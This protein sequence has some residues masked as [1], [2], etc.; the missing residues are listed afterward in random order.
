MKIA[1]ALSGGGFRAT[2]FHLGVLARLAHEKRLEEVKFL[3]TVSG[4]SLCIGLVFALNNNQW[5]ASENY[6]QEILPETRRLIT[7]FDL[8]RSMIIRALTSFW[9]IFETRADDLSALMQKHWGMTA[10]LRDLPKAPRFSAVGGYA[11]GQF[12]PDRPTSEEDT[13][14]L[15]S[16][17]HQWSTPNN[18]WNF[19]DI[20]WGGQPERYKTYP[21]VKRVP[22]PAPPSDRGLT[23]EEAIGKRRSVRNYSNQTLSLNAFSQLL[24]S[25]QGIT[26][27]QRSLRAAPSAGALYPIEVYSVVHNVGGLDPGIYHY[28]VQEHELEV[29]SIGDQRAQILQAGIW[30]EFLGEANVCF[31]LTAIF[32]RTRWKYQQ[33][34]YRYVLL[35][36]GHIAQNLYLSATSMNLGACAVGAFLDRDLNS[37]LGIDDEEEE[38]LYIISVGTI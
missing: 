14:D 34:A 35:E 10:S 8:Q 21:Q 30:Q 38:A 1:L 16:L 24:H 27:P 18:A 4:G 11:L 31:I 7:S 5:P 3:S 19:A 9:E 37:L 32:Q 25:A 29:L 22:L 28:A 13:T 20:H 26:E 33:R 17:Y 15:G 23:V 2:V 36:A 12:I 6:L